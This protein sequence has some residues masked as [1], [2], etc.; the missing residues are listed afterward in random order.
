MESDFFQLRRLFPTASTVI[1]KLEAHAISFIE[2]TNARSLKRGCVHKHVLATLVWF[3]EPESLCSVE[4][5]HG[6][7]HVRLRREAMSR[8]PTGGA[9]QQATFRSPPPPTGW[10][11]RE[12]GARSRIVHVPSAWQV[13]ARRN[14][15]PDQL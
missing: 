1:F 9:R 7:M 14:R 11:Q 8:T 3:D 4:E 5:L 6:A 15:L 12:E 2:R 13:E 10:H